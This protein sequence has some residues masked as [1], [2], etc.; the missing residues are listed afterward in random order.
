MA[1]PYKREVLFCTHCGEKCNKEIAEKIKYY[2]RNCGEARY[3]IYFVCPNSKK[4]W[5]NLFSQKH[6]VSYDGPTECKCSKK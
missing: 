4:F 1:K 5:E 6:T 2:C 3:E